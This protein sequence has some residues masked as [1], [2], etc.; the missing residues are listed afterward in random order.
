MKR[1]A[2]AIEERGIILSSANSINWVAACCLSWSIIFPHTATCLNSRPPSR[3]AKNQHLR[4]D[5]KLRK[6]ILAAFYAR[7]MGLPVKKLICA[8]MK[9][10]CFDGLYPHRRI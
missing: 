4:A 7:E 6:Q 8:S 9:T 5:R 3:P 2:N 10:S 1:S